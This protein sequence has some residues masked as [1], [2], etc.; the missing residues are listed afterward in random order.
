MTHFFRLLVW[1]LL[2]CVIHLPGTSVASGL[3][4]EFENDMPLL[5]PPIQLRQ[6]LADVPGSVTIITAEMINRF[7]IRSVPDA[8]RLVPGM[9]V[10]Q[11][12]GNDYR[13]NYH[14]TNIHAPKR[15][16]VLVDGMSVYRPAFGGV[17]WK[18]LPV[19]IENIERIE[20]TRGPNS[21]SFGVNSLLATVNIVTTHPGEVEGVT[22]TATVG[23]RKTVEGVSRYGGRLGATTAYAITAS[24][25]RDEGFGDASSFSRNHDGIQ[26]SKLNFRS[27]TDIDENETLDMQASLVRGEKE[28]AYVDFS[29]AYFPDIDTQDYYLSA[30]WRKSFSANHEMQIRAYQTR[31]KRNQKLKSCFPAATLLPQMADLWR[32]NPSYAEDVLA[33]RTPSGGSSTDDML[34]VCASEALA[35]LGAGVT[36]PVC[37]EMNQDSIENRYDI[38]LQDTVVFSDSLRMVNGFGFRRDT[39]S[40]QTYFGGDVSNSSWRLF[41]N[42]EYRPI[43]FLNIY[44]GGLLDMDELTGSS[45]SPRIALNGHI[46]NNQTIRFVMARAVRKPDLQEQRTN[47]SYQTSRLMPN[48][49]NV[50]NGNV[51]F[52]Q[53]ARAAGDVKSEK[54]LSKEMGYLAN[55]PRQGILLDVKIFEDELSDLVSEN[56]Q[57]SDFSPSNKNWVRLRGAELQ[58]TYTPND[59]WNAYLSYSRLRNDGSTAQEQTHYVKNSGA[60]GLTRVFDHDWRGS[61]VLYRSDAHTTGQSSYARDDLTLS[62]TYRMTGETSL[63]PTLT[64]S[65]F[66]NRPNKYVVDAARMNESRDVREMQYYLSLKF[67]Y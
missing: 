39:G 34:A 44:A 63:T 17:D 11:A 4:T 55:F 27:V 20:V 67:A 10:T 47:W 19:A 29:P 16:N 36:T 22:L 25:E 26:V 7:G 33:G 58:A 60:F 5:L 56:L 1:G 46:N 3:E 41:S 12:T 61:L 66:S 2:A 62:K 28:I 49:V 50:P 43:R 21:T 24:H 40:S 8:L 53:T 23:S 9:I 37:A 13:I 38:E 15:M 59:R 57:F 31:H 32:A 65:H 18:A 30:R 51:Q 54:N 64:I 45:F 48:I 14:G 42:V 6:S 52:Y 35:A